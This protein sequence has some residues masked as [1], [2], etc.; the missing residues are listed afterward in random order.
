[1]A[2]ASTKSAAQVDLSPE[3]FLKKESTWCS[4]YPE[5]KGWEDALREDHYT[6]VGK[7]EL[8][9]ET[10]YRFEFDEAYRDEVYKYAAHFVNV[11]INEKAQ[12][13]KL[14]PVIEVDKCPTCFK[15]L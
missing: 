4:A 6:L 13:P 15:P 2:W 11:L 5:I 1:M 3:F 8:E 7:C 10:L 9:G 12:E 14:P